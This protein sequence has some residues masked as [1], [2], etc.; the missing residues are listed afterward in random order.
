MKV[1]HFNIIFC[2]LIFFAI[3]LLSE[4]NIK[5]MKHLFGQVS[6]DQKHPVVVIDAGHGGFD[7][8]KIGVNKTLEKDINLAISQQV[9]EL[10][11]Q[12]DIK[13][14]MTRDSDKGLYSESDSNKKASDLKKR[15]E[16]INN[17]E[18]TLVVSIHQNSFT[19]ESSHGAQVFYYTNQEEGKRFANIMQ[20]QLKSTIQDNNHRVEKA[21]SSYY[22]LKKANCPIIIVECGFL[23]NYKEAELLSKEE[24][25]RKLAWAIHLGILKYLNSEEATRSFLN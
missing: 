15:V 7:P 9:K 25:Q 23:S 10:L 4:R 12:N 3:F 17:S 16:I 24:Y 1:R 11:E 14:V 21:N 6:N 22:L 20:L 18:A 5:A 13:V 2:L 19:E 8:G